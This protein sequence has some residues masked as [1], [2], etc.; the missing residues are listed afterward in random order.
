MSCVDAVV[1]DPPYGMSRHLSG[2]KVVGRLGHI[3][4]MTRPL[5]RPPLSAS[6][7]STFFGVPIILRPGCPTK[8]AGVACAKTGHRFIGIECEKEWFDLACERVYASQRQG[9]LW[10]ATNE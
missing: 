6:A 1:T 3:G 8:L 5:I 7:T 10:T 9:T 4:E 2:H